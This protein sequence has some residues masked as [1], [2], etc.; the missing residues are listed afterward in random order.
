MT[1]LDL[2]M[3]I[4]SVGWDEAIHSDE[5]SPVDLNLEDLRIFSLNSV[6]WDEVLQSSILV[7]SS[8]EVV[9][10]V[11]ENNHQEKKSQKKKSQISTS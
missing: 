10:Q 2:L 1:N 3:A 5:D 11:R 6:G 4:H 9:D 8:A 7:I